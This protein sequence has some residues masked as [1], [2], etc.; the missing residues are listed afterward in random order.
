MKKMDLFGPE[1]IGLYDTIVEVDYKDEKYLVRD[2][3]AIFRKIR[4]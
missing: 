4:V 2:N 1:L 3:G